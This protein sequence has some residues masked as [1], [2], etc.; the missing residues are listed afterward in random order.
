MFHHAKGRHDGGMTHPA[1]IFSAHLCS[2]RLPSAI[3]VL[4]LIRAFTVAGVDCVVVQLDCRATF[5]RGAIKKVR[6][7]FFFCVPYE[8]L[9]R[10]S[11]QLETLWQAA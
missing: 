8:R 9:K 6:L 1:A 3:S 5:I 4:P 11:S 2:L 7:S 10:V